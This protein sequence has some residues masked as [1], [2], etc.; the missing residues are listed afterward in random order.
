[1][2]PTGQTVW[3]GFEPPLVSLTRNCIAVMLPDLKGKPGLPPGQPHENVGAGVVR[4]LPLL[5][6]II[7]NLSTPICLLHLRVLPSKLR[8]PIA[9]SRT[10]FGHGA[11]P[12]DSRTLSCW[13][14]GP[15]PCTCPGISRMVDHRWSRVQKRRSQDKHP[16]SYLESWWYPLYPPPKVAAGSRV[17]T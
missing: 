9:N 12:S 14:S 11:N 15:A 7:F 5:Y 1:M 3:G 16:S 17:C 10:D 8:N 13:P 2:F 6:C 4:F